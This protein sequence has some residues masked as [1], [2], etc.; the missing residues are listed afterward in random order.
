MPDSEVGERRRTRQEE[1]WTLVGLQWVLL[2][3]F[4]AVLA[5]QQVEFSKSWDQACDVDLKIWCT[6]WI[7]RQIVTLL[8]QMVGSHFALCRRSIR[9]RRIEVL[10]Y[11]KK[12]ID[13]FSFS[14]WLYG[15]YVVLATGDPENC[16]KSTHT[17]G[18]VFWYLQL[19][20][21]VIPCLLVVVLLP[22]YFCCV[23]RQT[24][25]PPLK[26]TPDDCLEK[27]EV[28]TWKSWKGVAAQQAASSSQAPRTPNNLSPTDGARQVQET[29]LSSSQS[30]SA[31]FV[32]VPSKPSALEFVK[33]V[34]REMSGHSVAESIGKNNVDT[35][36]A[37]AICYVDYEDDDELIVMPCAGRH[38]YHKQCL[39]TWLA[40]S[41][42]CPMCRG[43]I[44]EILAGGTGE[45]EAV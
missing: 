30:H 10:F 3:S 23:P 27:L 41:Q 11:V 42:L 4:V 21:V 36:E 15:I 44:V 14:W 34:A 28:T 7:S 17:W 16:N 9:I 32:G 19:A 2:G 38:F 40:K 31:S 24:S 39:V 43:N 18:L 35:Q 20:F 1:L 6:V 25:Q 13:T 5:V 12:A 26:P 29:T 8:L 33:V 37:C 22:C 45:S